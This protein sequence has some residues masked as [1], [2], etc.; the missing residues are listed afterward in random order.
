[1]SLDDET[2]ALLEAVAAAGA[3]RLH[4]LSP[5]EARAAMKGRQAAQ[6]PG[7][8]MARVVEASVAVD[9]G[10]IAVRVLVPAGAPS[11]TIVFVHGG[12]WVLDGL[13]GFDALGRRLAVA[14]GAA[15]VLVDYRVAPEHPFPVPLEDSWSALGWARTTL[16]ALVPEA[17]GLP[18][19]IGGDS[20]GGAIAAA[21]ALRAAREGVPL[22]A[23]LLVYPVT[24]AALDTPSYLDPE[25]QLL[26]DR[27]TMA[28]FWDQYVPEAGA[29]GDPAVSPLRDEIPP[30]LAPAVV[31]VAEHDVLRDEGEA[32]AARLVAA[33]VPVESRRFAG[34]MHGFLGLAQLPG[35]EAAFAW[36][37][38]A[39]RR[40]AP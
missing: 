20:A 8:E 36:I 35:G 29:R 30:G 18:V 26:V 38:A 37:G 22:A 19:A 4:G 3:P 28:W 17:A 2:R 1:M 25:N 16:P 40:L 11:V 24:D 27:A 39:L 5:P 15:V 12:G 14:A 33:G 9:G 34:Q 23:Q 21:I 13:G 7:P 6:P 31:A 32:Y 10:R